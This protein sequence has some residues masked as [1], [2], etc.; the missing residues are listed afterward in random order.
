MGNS[1][2]GCVSIALVSITLCV[3]RKNDL[4]CYLVAMMDIT[5]PCLTLVSALVTF[6]LI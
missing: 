2:F 1:R 3:A 6:L 4:N 5:L